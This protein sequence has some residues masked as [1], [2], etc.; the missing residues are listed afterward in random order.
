MIASINKHLHKHELN[1]FTY[2]LLVSGTI[3]IL[4]RLWSEKIHIENSAEEGF[5]LVKLS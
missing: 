1:S 4:V 3:I 5:L 2:V